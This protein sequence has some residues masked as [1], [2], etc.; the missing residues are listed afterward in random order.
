MFECKNKKFKKY[1]R[2]KYKKNNFKQ[3][4]KL[5]FGEYGLKALEDCYLKIDQINSVVKSIRRT[6]RKKNKLFVNIF[7]DYVITQKPRDVRMG[8][9]KGNPSFKIYPLK[10]GKVILEI[11]ATPINIALRALKTGARR[12]PINTLIIEKVNNINNG[13]S[14]DLFESG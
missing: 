11:R 1:F 4:D 13:T 9:G 6:V 2:V 14:R 5:C 12:L 7:P 3:Y 10:A 8:R